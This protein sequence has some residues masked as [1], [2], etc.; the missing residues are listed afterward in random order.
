MFN[1]A[2]EVVIHH[3]SEDLWD[4]MLDRA[5]LSGA[6][7]A[8]GS[9]PDGDALRLLEVAVDAL[10][11][12]PSEVLR[13]FGREAMPMLAARYPRYFAGYGSARSFV[14]A[15]NGVVHPEVGQMYPDTNAPA[16]NF[17]DEP[18]GSLTMSYG[19]ERK[20]CALAQGLIEGAA[21]HFGETLGFEHL[22]CM[23]EGAETCLCRISFRG[24]GRAHTA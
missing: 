22:R 8:M 7:T 23:N 4:T 18:D 16:L 2:Q 13:W 24:P 17:S 19:S 3:R 10:D 9:Y 11:S 15:V 21:E 12:T 5:G 6:Y 1:L 20:L 14:L